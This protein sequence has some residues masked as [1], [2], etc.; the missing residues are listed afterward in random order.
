[1]S[2]LTEDL[3]TC[4]L[5]GLI[6]S[7]FSEACCASG[8]SS[9]QRTWTPFFF[10]FSLYLR[11]LWLCAWLPGACANGPDIAYLSLATD[12]LLVTRYDL[13]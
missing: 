10:S 1:V 4:G 9:S 7:T 13:I 6:I 12:F 3:S 5:L 2:N 11:F 8:R